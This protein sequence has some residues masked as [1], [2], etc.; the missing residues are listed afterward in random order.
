[1]NREREVQVFFVF[2]FP[3]KI[4]VKTDKYSLIFFSSYFDWPFN[5]P[6]F[7]L[8]TIKNFDDF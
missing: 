6:N 7:F 3:E 1:M 5:A 4:S 8:E 2:F